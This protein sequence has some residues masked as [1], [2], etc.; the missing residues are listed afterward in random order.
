MTLHWSTEGGEQ[1]EEGSG[2]DGE[3]DQEDYVMPT[4]KPVHGARSRRAA[5]R[6]VPQM[7]CV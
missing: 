1:D 3:E 7:R 2:G 6:A 5:P 4:F